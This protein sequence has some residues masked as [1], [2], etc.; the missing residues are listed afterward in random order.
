VAKI[1]ALMSQDNVLQVLT[2]VDIVTIPFR[3]AK[4]AAEAFDKISKAKEAVA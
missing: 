1:V 3:N 4:S 2:D